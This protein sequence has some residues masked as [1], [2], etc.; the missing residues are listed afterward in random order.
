[1]LTPRSAC[2]QFSSSKGAG[3]S[4][5]TLIELLVVIAIIAVLIGLLLPA[6]QKVR[7]AAAR[8]QS[9]NNLKQ[10]GLAIQN[11]AGDYNGAMAPS[12]GTFPSYNGPTGSMFCFL[13]PYME[14]T[15]VYNMYNP[16]PGGTFAG[17]IAVDVKPYI[18]PGDPSFQAGQGLTSYA[19]NGL[20]FGNLGARLPSTFQDG[21]SNTVAFME[22]YAISTSGQHYWSNYNTWVYPNTGSGFQVKPALTAAND[23]QPQGMSSAGLQ[24]GLADGSV[25][26]V[27]QGVS[28]NTWYLACNPADGMAMP[29]DW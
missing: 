28:L 5:F 9:S 20:V 22:R 12:Y 29:S 21:T 27:S 25:R 19:S 14:Q 7:E 17:Q 4:A 13:L 26:N 18:A 2:R 3:R 6:V 8:T 10:M 15:N 24:V 23:S 16:G 1:M 11:M